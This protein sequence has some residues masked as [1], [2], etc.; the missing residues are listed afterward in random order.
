ML[1]VRTGVLRPLQITAVRSRQVP[2][3]FAAGAGVGVDEG[4]GEGDGVGGGGLEVELSLLIQARTALLWGFSA[5]VLVKIPI[6]CCS[7]PARVCGSS[8]I[9]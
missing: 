4:P 9:S 6:L 2:R 8:S 5:P 7:N 1:T 3:K